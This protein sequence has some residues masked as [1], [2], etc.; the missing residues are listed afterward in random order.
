MNRSERKASA[1]AMSTLSCTSALA[2]LCATLALFWAIWVSTCTICWW[3]EASKLKNAVGI[4]ATSKVKPP[5]MPAAILNF[6]T[7]AF[8]SRLLSCASFMA[9]KARTGTISPTKARIDSTALNLLYIGKYSKKRSETSGKFL[10]NE[11]SM[12]KTVVP[13]THHFNLFLTMSKPNTN[14][15]HTMAPK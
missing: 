10:P 4:T 7:S 3:V 2:I 6:L 1:R 15:K 11:S 14:R 9:R 13:K 12:N 8:W 5:V